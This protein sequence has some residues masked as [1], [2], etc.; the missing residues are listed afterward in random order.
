[1]VCPGCRTEEELIVFLFS[2]NSPV[3]QLLN[4]QDIIMFYF[5]VVH[6]SSVVILILFN[7]SDILFTN[8]LCRLPMYVDEKFVIFSKSSG[9]STF[10]ETLI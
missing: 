2:P 8:Q 4:I 3:G 10:C 6:H 9:R 7:T 5:Y 1:M